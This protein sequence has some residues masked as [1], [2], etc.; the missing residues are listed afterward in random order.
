[1]N[2]P[3]LEDLI[4]QVFREDLYAGAAIVDP[5]GN[6]LK[7]NAYLCN[8]LGY[9]ESEL[10]GMSFEQITNPEDLKAEQPY[11]D[12]VI[13]GAIDHYQFK[14]RYSGKDGQPVWGVLDRS[15]ARDAERKPKYFISRIRAITPEEFAE[16]RRPKSL[17]TKVA[18]RVRSVFGKS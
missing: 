17:W 5:D 18:D 1:M 8:M 2:D 3:V 13:A 14:T 9:E 15:V 4:R 16:E 11:L 12:R 6:W 7:V 10:L